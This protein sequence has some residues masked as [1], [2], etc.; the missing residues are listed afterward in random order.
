M[1]T[2]VSS[3]YRSQTFKLQ[4]DIDSAPIFEIIKS[5]RGFPFPGDML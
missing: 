1:S 5:P 4:E 3:R 2:I